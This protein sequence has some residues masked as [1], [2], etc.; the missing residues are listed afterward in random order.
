MLDGSLD[1]RG[2][3]P[4]GFSLG[5][6]GAERNV[7]GRHT[8]RGAT[9]G[10]RHRGSR[11]VRPKPRQIR[12]SAREGISTQKRAENLIYFRIFRVRIF[13]AAKTATAALDF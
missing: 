10:V 12:G 3:F 11:G 6:P 13:A 8:A 7:P 5:T 2:V 9:L 1:G 4:A